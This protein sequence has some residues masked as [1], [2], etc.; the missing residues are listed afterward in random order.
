[1]PETGQIFE[2]TKS[3]NGLDI[4]FSSTMALIDDVCKVVTLFIE[5]RGE[6]VSPHVFAVN[7]VIREGLTNAVRHGNKTDPKKTVRLRM[8]LDASS[9]IRVS[10]QDQG[11]GFDWQAAR[12][13]PLFEAADHGRG[14][15]IMNTYF[16][17]CRYNT[18]GNVLYLEK[19]I[20]SRPQHEI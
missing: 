5:S 17:R 6:A 9:I 18:A 20:R 12:E 8:A 2:L 4:R 16:D 7:L 19:D 10:I 14:M 13:K 3:E 15:S 1:M 11:E